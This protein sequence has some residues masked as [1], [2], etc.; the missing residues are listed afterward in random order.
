MVITDPAMS[1]SSKNQ[2]HR[3]GMALPC[4]SIGIAGAGLMGRMLGFDL[5]LA[6]HKVHIFDF[7]DETGSQ[8]CAWTGA[9]ML[10]PYS[11]LES[12]DHL[13][14]ALGVDSI[15]LWPKLI[16]KL[17]IGVFFQQNGTLILAHGR[18][19]ADLQRFQRNL[20]SKLASIT[21]RGWATT[22]PHVEA[23][24]V[25]PQQ[26]EPG[27]ENRFATGLFLE[28]EGQV[29]NRQLLPAL[30]A[31]LTAHGVQWS[32]K[33]QVKEMRPYSI[34]TEG[35]TFNFDCVIDCRG[36]GSRVDLPQLRGVR[37]EIIRVLAPEVSLCRPVRLMHPRY[38]L[39]IAPRESD[40]FVV[41]ATMIE[42][43]DCSP[44]TVQSALELLSA[45]FSVHPGFANAS[46]IEM[47]AQCRPALPDNLPRIF[48]EPGLM[49]VNGLFRH[50]FLIA[51]KLV[52]LATAI[53]HKEAIEG[54]YQELL[55]VEESKIA[56]AC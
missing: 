25:H 33:T 39:Y 3:T 50:G 4:P 13:I 31:G 11:E 37:G 10:A 54:R 23:K 29:D 22:S 45:A 2:N 1:R 32:T 30:A 14:F 36:M 35:A 5:L 43:D 40:H 44:V 12:A 51:P 49:R 9:G 34:V 28:E 46:I 55:I 6:G 19:Q 20:Q 38:P 24:S 48:V 15:K 8:S 16:D 42:S 17:P 27:L 56:S 18:D 53:L 7:D 52:E 41:G 26:L 21:G 47:G